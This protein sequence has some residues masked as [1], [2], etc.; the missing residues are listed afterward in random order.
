MEIWT[1][2]KMKK[3][4]WWFH[5]WIVVKDN[6][7]SYSTTLDFFFVW[8]KWMWKDKHYI[9]MSEEEISE[10]S[11]LEKIKLIAKTFK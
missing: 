3:W 1:F 5:N 11:F 7:C 4:D 9:K 8:N 2:I 6:D 10:L